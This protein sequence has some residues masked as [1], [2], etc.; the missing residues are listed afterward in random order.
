MSKVVHLSNSSHAE[1][2]AY[3]K[4]RGLR[5][6]DWV[7][8]LIEQAIEGLQAAER[9]DVVLRKKPV[10]RLDENLGPEEMVPAYAMPPFWARAL[11]WPPSRDEGLPL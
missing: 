10:K 3:C 8:S 9:S 4:D 6:S 7:A 2:K 5:M 1:A 11:E